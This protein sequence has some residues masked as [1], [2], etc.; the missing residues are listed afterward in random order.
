MTTSRQK[1]NRFFLAIA[2]VLS[3]AA[4]AS[5]LALIGFLYAWNRAAPK[6]P[7]GDAIYAYS[8]HGDITYFNAAQSTAS[9]LFLP[10]GACFVASVIIALGAYGEDAFRSRP[11]LPTGDI[12]FQFLGAAIAATVIGFFGHDILAALI[13]TPFGPVK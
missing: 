1:P 6:M 2:G 3:G 7:A 13:A 8:D 11:R 9:H 4:F 12:R 10:L 5:I